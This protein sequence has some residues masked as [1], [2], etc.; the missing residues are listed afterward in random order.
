[1]C[2]G[3]ISNLRCAAATVPR[4]ACYLLNFAKNSQFS[5]ECPGETGSY[6]TAHTTIQSP[7]TARFRYHNNTRLS[8][9]HQ[10]NSHP[11]FCS[12]PTITHFGGDFWRPVSASQ[13]S[14]PGGQPLPSA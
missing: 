3:Y 14:V 4:K 9:G 1:M 10:V 13:N 7:Q 5:G 2:L 12:L 6:L 11:V 8:S